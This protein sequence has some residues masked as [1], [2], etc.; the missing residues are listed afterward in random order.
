[1]QDEQQQQQQKLAV[2]YI[3]YQFKCV[4]NTTGPFTYQER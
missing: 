2:Y 1:M 3:P 4:I